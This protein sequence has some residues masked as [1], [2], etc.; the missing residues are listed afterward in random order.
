MSQTFEAMVDR[1]WLNLTC[2]GCWHS[3]KLDPE[4]LA[5]RYGGKTE[6]STWVR[7]CKCVK[8]GRKWPA[9]TVESRLPTIDW[10]PKTYGPTLQNSGGHTRVH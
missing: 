7:R 6:V 8:C 9:V 4:V 1:F 10:N 5:A 2:R 3:V